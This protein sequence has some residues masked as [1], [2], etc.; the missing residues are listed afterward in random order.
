ME[1]QQL[2]FQMERALQIMLTILHK[3]RCI[4]EVDDANY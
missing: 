2:A 3:G 4:R 1:R